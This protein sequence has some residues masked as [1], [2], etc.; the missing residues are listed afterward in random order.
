[1]SVE[2]SSPEMMV[3]QTLRAATDPNHEVVLKAEA[4]LAE[5]E[6]QP[7]FF[8]TLAR[9]STLHAGNEAGQQHLQIDLNV[10]W[11]AAVYLKNGINKYWRRNVRHEL[12]SEE[13]QQIREIL[14]KKFSTEPVP[15]VML[16][17]AVLIARIAR[18]D[19]PRDW[20]ELIPQLMKQ[21][22][23]CA[24]T[25]GDAGEQ[26][27]V[28]LVLH[29]VVKALA[30]RRMMAEK[31]VFEELT[32]NLFVYMKDIWDAFTTLFFHQ[33]KTASVNAISTLERALLTTRI[34][35][36]LTVYG[37]SKP[38]KIECCMSFLELL[39]ARLKQC[40][41][42][43]YELQHLG[44]EDQLVALMEKFILKQIKTLT[45]FQDMHSS[46]FARFVPEAL[47][48][49]F[50][51]VFYERA[52]LIFSENVI[53]FSNFAI[54]CINLMKGIM[55][56]SAY[57]NSATTGEHVLT[58][59][60]PAPHIALSDF[61]T[62]DRLSYICE[63]IITHYFLLTQ[64]ELDQWMEDAESFAQDDGGE[65]WKYALRPCIESFFLTCF[66]QYQTKMTAEVVKYIRK[67]QQIELSPSSDLKDI[68]IKDAIY[69]AAGL[70]SFHFFNDIDFDVW[71]GNQLLSELRIESDNFRILRRRIIWLVAEWA[72]VKFS[73]NLRPLAYEAC[74]HLLR[75]TEDMSIRLAAS[76]TLSTLIGDF[77]FA[78]EPFLPYLEPS[79][80]ALFVLLGEARECDTKMNVLTI[81][82]CLVEKMSDNI[83]PQADNLISY[84]PL[85]WKESEDYNMLRCAIICTLQQLAKALRDIPESMKPFLY[86]VIQLSTDLQEPSHIYLIEE[87]L[88]LWVAVV[89]NSTVMS[90]QLLALCKN[91]LPII[92]MSSENLRI[93]L[94]LI[95]AYILLDSHTF[96][97]RYGMEFVQFCTRMFDD[98]RPEGIALMLKVFETCLKS[99]A[100]YGLELVRPAL[101]YIFKQVYL[102]K[103]FPMLMSM[104]LMMVARVLLISQSVFT[105]VLQELQL[106]NALETILDVWIRKM[107]LVTEV[108]KRKLFAL[109]F[110]SIFTN[111]QILLERFPGIMQNIGDTLMDVM[112]EEDDEL[113]TIDSIDTV[114]IP[115]RPAGEKPM[116]FCDSLVFLDEHD[117]DTSSYCIMDDFD[118][119]TYHYDR[120]R[121]LSLKDPVHK[122]VL[123]EYLEWQ[124]NTLRTQMGED[125]Y[126]QL[127]QCVDPGVLEKVGKFVKLNLNFQPN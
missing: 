115:P 125:A 37:F 121:Q 48:F 44:A 30:S 54:H 58:E 106:P 126:Q 25:E 81:M 127:M 1:M 79:F 2:L 62:D 34:L 70:A 8:P 18:I 31:R 90:P 63:K 6:L 42:C 112:R 91:L 96:L 94:I 17:I 28:L 67:A 98:L 114:N 19:C 36:K 68:L 122:I 118:Y 105:A 124:L 80:N 120:C 21:L 117:L 57:A 72:A 75:S 85:L 51:H 55:M 10:R 20:P 97:E 43:R 9:F 33:L 24:Q 7:G 35:R 82:S 64:I 15:Q 3:C 11:M 45:E 76:R 108:E 93:V 87:G 65:S 99:D 16:Q 110:A 38:F 56:C 29:H 104:Y 39:F 113:D 100:N 83:E 101:P 23:I 86:N 123:T 47:E 52:R 40:L 77:E 116:K 84:L 66:S 95:Q 103:E 22:Q 107:P 119:K 26:H 61:F 89:E 92:E 5:W 111:D 60:N 53:N 4:Q 59:P 41:E 109:A 71:F 32:G 27:R 12:P 69:N 13:K 78:P 88:A 46:S 74:L 102:D 50:E 49:S 14:L 73:R